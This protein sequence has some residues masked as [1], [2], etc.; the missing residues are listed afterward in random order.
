MR[1]SIFIIALIAI[2][3]SCDETI[4]SPNNGE[5][6]E[7]QL[8]PLKL[9]NQWVYEANN[10]F[11]YSQV[12]WTVDSVFTYSHDG[13][14]IAMY[15]TLGDHGLGGWRHTYYYRNGSLNNTVYWKL[16][17][18]NPTECFKYPAETG[19]RWSIEYSFYDNI[20][21]R[22]Y[23]L[24]SKNVIVRV[25]AGIFRCYEYQ[26]QTTGVRPDTI[27]SSGSL[28][29]HY[30]TPGIGRIATKVISID[31]DDSSHVEEKWTS[32]LVSFDID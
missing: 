1:I 26:V 18:D 13:E 19:E 5:L 24:K 32:R 10:D 15:S 29:N 4:E 23:C 27:L 12:I 20:D 21:I 7:E 8:V 2:I 3:T 28:V 31:P 16:E 30:Y 14:D 9:H 25:P 17:P 22:D 6:N 11:S